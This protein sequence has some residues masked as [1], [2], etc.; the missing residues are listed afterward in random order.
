MLLRER[1]AMKAA[2]FDV[3]GTLVDS[4]DLHAEAWQRAFE[5]FGHR[6]T[7]EQARSQ[8]GKGGDQLM[9]VFLSPDELKAHGKELETWRGDL[10]KREYLQRVRAFPKVRELFQRLLADDWA[11]GLA[12]S[13]KEDE[14]KI[15]EEIAG[16]SDLLDAATSSNDAAKSK[17]HPDI[18][19]AAAARLHVSAN[20][21]IVIGDSPYDAE[22]AGKA[23]MISVGLLCGGFPRRDL[24]AAGFSFLYQDAQDV[25]THY[26]TSLFFKRAPVR[27]H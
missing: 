25:L 23:G 12:S 11:I 3:D 17:P 14:L 22:A 9:P 2:I 7:F 5:H 10:F 6:V 26:D 4:V 19:Q 21:C 8:I 24:E 16:V 13:A 27:D 20:D 1:C 15:Y 18:F